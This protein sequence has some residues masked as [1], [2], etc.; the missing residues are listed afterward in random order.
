[1]PLAGVRSYPGAVTQ[2]NLPQSPLFTL[3]FE[4]RVVNAY[5]DE[6]LRDPAVLAPLDGIPEQSDLAELIMPDELPRGLRILSATPVLRFDTTIGRLRMAIP[7]ATDRPTTRA[8]VEQI[9]TI[10]R[11]LFDTGWGSNYHFDL[12]ASLEQFCVLFDDEPLELRP[13]P[14]STQVQAFVSR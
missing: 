8:E 3:T 11:A 13:A 14:G 4:A 5:T 1:L 6:E 7:F 10:L 9:A 12:P 2:T